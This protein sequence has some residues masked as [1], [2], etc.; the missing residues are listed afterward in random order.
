[1]DR[2]SITGQIMYRVPENAKSAAHG[3]GFCNNKEER[4]MKKIRLLFTYSIDSNCE[5]KKCINIKFLLN[6][7]EIFVHSCV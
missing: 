3:C 5:E 7:V 4:K 2:I 6:A 1:M